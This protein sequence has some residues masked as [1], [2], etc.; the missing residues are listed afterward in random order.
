M[1]AVATD[2]VSGSVVEGVTAAATGAA[3][4]AGAAGS[5]GAAD[6]VSGAVVDR[7]TAPPARTASAACGAA[8]GAAEPAYGVSRRGGALDVRATAVTAG[9]AVTGRP[10]TARPAGSGG[11]MSGSR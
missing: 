5:G 6:G 8:A 9:T 7:V 10:V 4:M 3:V 11:D 2:G 1:H